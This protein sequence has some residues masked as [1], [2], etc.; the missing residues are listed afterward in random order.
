MEVQKLPDCDA[1]SPGANRNAFSKSP[2]KKIKAES[3]TFKS[4]RLAAGPCVKINGK[5]NGFSKHSKKSFS[6][7]EKENS[8]VLNVK[9][10]FDMSTVSGTNEFDLMMSYSSW[11]QN[12]STEEKEAFLNCP[13]IKKRPLS[14]ADLQVKDKIPEKTLAAPFEDD[15]T[16]LIDDWFDDGMEQKSETPK[17]KK[18][19][20]EYECFIQCIYMHISEF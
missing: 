13:I 17:P 12:G 5:T 19:S 2:E 14:T 9:P 20:H 8:L 3:V 7:S 10:E 11:I 16:G 18:F 4:S 6:T 1:S 15:F